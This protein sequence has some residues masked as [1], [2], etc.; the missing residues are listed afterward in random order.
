MLTA[1]KIASLVSIAGPLDTLVA[2]LKIFPQK[3][4]NI[5]VKSKPALDSL[6]EVARALKE[7]EAALGNSGRVVLRYSGTE[8]LARVMV[9]AEREEDVRRWTEALAA[10]LRTAIGA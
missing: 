3:I 7:A 6:P 4:V 5:P 2:D 8:S 10:A 9:E 1:M